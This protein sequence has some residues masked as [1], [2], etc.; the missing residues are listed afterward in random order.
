MSGIHVTKVSMT[1]DLK[2]PANDIEKHLPASPYVVGEQIAEQVLD[3]VNR[4][5]LGY[6]PALDYFRDREDDLDKD[7]INAAD[8]ITWLVSNMVREEITRRLRG[9]FSNVKI[10]S[11]HAHAFTMPSIRKN[12]NNLD[13]KLAI[14]YTPDHFKVALTLSSI[15]N[16]NDSETA[17][18]LAKKMVHKWLK[19]EFTSFN[20]TSSKIANQDEE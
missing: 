16:H 2:V 20:V 19:D 13:H 6:F 11:I 18:V 1:L 3:Y 4:S 17:D 10:E 12:V 8:N 9:I 7:L 5:K 15:R 14:H